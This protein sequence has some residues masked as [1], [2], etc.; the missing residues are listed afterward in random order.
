MLP[1]IHIGPFTIALYGVMMVTGLF[2]GYHLLAA[3][4]RR[5][6]IVG[7]NPLTITVT[8]GLGGLLFSKL[9][10]IVIYPERFLA[11]PGFLLHRAGYAFYGAVLGDLIVLVA[12][13]RRY[14]VPAAKLLDALAVPCAIGYGIG[15]IGCFLAGDGDYG[16]PTDLPWG[17]RF[18]HGLV[19]TL[20]PV[21]P[22]QLYE[23]AVSAL[24]ASWLWQRGA[25]PRRA[26]LAPGHLFALYLIG[27]GLARFFVEFIKRNPPVVFGLVNAQLVALASIVGGG[28]WWWRTRQPAVVAA[29]TAA[30][31]VSADS[32]ARPAWAATSTSTVT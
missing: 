18:P 12:L 10:L 26:E 1:F 15:R 24:L 13:A 21:H 7:V 30:G 23:F 22:A 14:R 11:N 20:V 3:E 31:G 27:S 17:M 29:A 8:L 19:P 9:Y 2:V 28:I 25:P 6:G 16:V 5:G 4:L 32:G